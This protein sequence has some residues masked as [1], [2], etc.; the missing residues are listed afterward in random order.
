MPRFLPR[1]LAT[2][3][4]YTILY[5]ISSGSRGGTTKP[6]SSI[7]VVV[8][9]I[10]SCDTHVHNPYKRLSLISYADTIEYDEDKDEYVTKV[11]RDEQIFNGLCFET[12]EGLQ[13]AYWTLFNACINRVEA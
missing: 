8:S 13:L 12:T 3:R 5:G 6:I 7:G 10:S 11:L 4:D 9:H 2:R 1:Y